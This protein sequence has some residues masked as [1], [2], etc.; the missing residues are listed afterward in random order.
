M[1][2]AVINALLEQVQK[3]PDQAFN[4]LQDLVAI[5]KAHPEVVSALVKLIPSK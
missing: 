3:S 2:Q 5:L 1:W 4:L